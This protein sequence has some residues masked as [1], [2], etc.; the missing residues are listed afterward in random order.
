M[1]ARRILPV[2]F[3]AASAAAVLT[4]SLPAQAHGGGDEWAWRSR[5]L[6]E[7]Q[8]E[9]TWR[10]QAWRER[11]W[12]ERAWRHEMAERRGWGGPPSGGHYA[13]QPRG[14]YGPRW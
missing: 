4:T 9:R 1:Q 2:L 13:Y 6:A 5:E 7:Q 12:R 14:Y 11:V 10:E 8:R 3:A